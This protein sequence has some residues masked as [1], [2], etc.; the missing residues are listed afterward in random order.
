MAPPF[1]LLSAEGAGGLFPSVRH[2]GSM[3]T[4]GLWSRRDHWTGSSVLLP[5]VGPPRVSGFKRRS[6]LSS[7]ADGGE[8]A[9]RTPVTR[10]VRHLF[11]ES[12][13]RD[14]CPTLG[15]KLQELFLK[16]AV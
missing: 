4:A 11:H 12:S 5:S 3:C 9:V 15:G 16:G 6:A 14:R 8:E 13:F 2:V 10:T 7:G 1:S